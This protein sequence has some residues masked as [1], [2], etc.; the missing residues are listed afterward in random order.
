MVQFKRK[1]NHQV[2]IYCVYNNSYR[3]LHQKRIL[4]ECALISSLPGK[5]MRAQVAER[6][7]LKAKPGKLQKT[8]TWYSVYLFTHWFALQT[9]NYDL[10]FDF[11]VD[12]AS[13]ATSFKKWNVI[14]TC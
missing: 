12:S 9:S 2:V 5:A 1:S 8:Q 7:V 13:L 3:L 6:S 14:M 11:C 10:I 4:G